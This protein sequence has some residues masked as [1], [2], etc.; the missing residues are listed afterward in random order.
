MFG[1]VNATCESSP[2]LLRVKSADCADMLSF[3]SHGAAVTDVTAEHAAV[4]SDIHLRN[5]LGTR[6]VVRRELYCTH[7]KSTTPD[8]DCFK[9]FCGR[10]SFS[11]RNASSRC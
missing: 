2:S 10:A 3:D 7:A 9:A 11:S 1:K 5:A 8:C 6:K 4:E